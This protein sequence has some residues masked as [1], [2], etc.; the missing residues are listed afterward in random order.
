[1]EK[2]LRKQ[3]LEL[4]GERF[5]PYMINRWRR[6]PSTLVWNYSL[7]YLRQARFPNTRYMDKALRTAAEYLREAPHILLQRIKNLLRLLSG[8]RFRDD[9][10]DP[11]DSRL[12]LKVWP[13]RSETCRATRETTVSRESRCIKSVEV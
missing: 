4:L 6:H 9:K 2:A 8:G 1:M 5:Y 3:V 13:V 10:I 11:C 12:L 7:I